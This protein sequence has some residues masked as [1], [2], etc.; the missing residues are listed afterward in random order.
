ME[1]LETGIESWNETRKVYRI[2]EFS[3]EALLKP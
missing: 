2:T 1:S 3:Q